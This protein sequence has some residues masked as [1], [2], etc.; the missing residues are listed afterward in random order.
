MMKILET[1]KVQ[2]VYGQG[3]TEVR[4]LDNVSM[5]VEKGEFVA[6]VGTSGSGKS[7]L[8]HMIGGLDVPTAGE[9][10]VDGQMLSKMTDEELTI[11]R[12][13]NIGF[14]CQQYNLVPMLN[15]WENIVLPVKLDG[16]K[17]KKEY[18]EEII[19][20][21][22]LKGKLENL[23]NAL[24][25]G[26]QQRVAIARALASNPAIL[27]ADEPNGMAIQNILRNWKRGLIVML[28]I[29]LSMVVVDAIVMLVQGYDFKS[30]QKIFLSSDFQLDQMTTS[31][32]NTNFNGIS[33]DVQK[34][35]KDSPYSE[36]CGFVYYSDEKHKMEEGM[37]KKWEDYKKEYESSWSE[38]DREHWDALQESGELK[39]HFMGINEAAFNKLEWK[40]APCEWKDFKD[41]N[42]VIVDYNE[43]YSKG[44]ALYYQP[45]DTY[46]MQYQSGIE[47]DYNV[48]GEALMPY[49]LGYP[50]Y[51]MFYITVLVPDTEYKACVENDAAM[52]AAVDVKKGT[53]EQMQKYIEQ[54]VLS[55]NER[56]NVFSVLNMRESFQ[57]Y[58]QKYYMIGGCLA[59]VLAFIGIMNFFNTTATSVLNRKRELALL[60][61]VGMTKKQVMKMLVAEGFIYL[62]GAF[63]LAVVIICTSAE[64]LLVNTV[65]N[66][67]FFQMH[68][69]LVPC[70]CM[71]PLMAVI[72][73]VIPRKL[74][75]KMAKESITM[76]IRV[77]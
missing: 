77:E 55:E 57:K 54:N 29:A 25:G 21:L 50:Y 35:L 14:V 58:V 5:E 66:A 4:A 34:K 59:V 51:D 24:S 22:G 38:A 31:L 6:I 52:Y 37:Q 46:Q 56:I 15:V 26:Q 75:R 17:P 65:G 27:L 19:E 1:K 7:T 23:P 41:G 36:Q 12:R 70:I 53:E 68:L 61:A 2:K 73:Y 18:L 45:G 8:L 48:L 67:F 20:I 40:D 47:K 3:D 74:F 72:A 62:A 71:L 60:E 30:Y 76:R 44:P 10:M 63:I 9:V 32:G 33:A 16:N 39:V 69:N 49:S 43:M 64:K 42:S 11:F 13:R 28:S